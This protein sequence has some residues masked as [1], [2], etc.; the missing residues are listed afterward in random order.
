MIKIRKL[1]DVPELLKTALIP[2]IDTS[3][4]S[5]LRNLELHTSFT[6]YSKPRF[7]VAE[8]RQ[9]PFVRKSVHISEMNEL[10]SILDK[11][12]QVLAK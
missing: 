7:V 5:A 8:V 3:T 11:L 10:L 1:A 9:N 6:I 4:C 12:G 2:R